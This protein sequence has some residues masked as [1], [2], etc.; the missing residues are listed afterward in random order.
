[1]ATMGEAP[2][3]THVPTM[4]GGNGR[5]DGAALLRDLV[6]RPLAEGHGRSRRIS[7]TVGREPSVVDEIDR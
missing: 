4:T 1:M 5:E 2:H 6:H 3:V 7:R